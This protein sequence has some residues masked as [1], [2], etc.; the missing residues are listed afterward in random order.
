VR[1]MQWNGVK[2]GIIIQLLKDSPVRLIWFIEGG[3]RRRSNIDRNNIQVN[4]SDSTSSFSE[5]NH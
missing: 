1:D 4:Y 5:G 3:G 2:N